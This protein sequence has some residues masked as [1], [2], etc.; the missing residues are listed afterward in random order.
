MY[1]IDKL[2][3]LPCSLTMW[4]K[5][6]FSF[7]VLCFLTECPSVASNGLLGCGGFVKSDIDIN[8]SLVEVSDYEMK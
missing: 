5:Y 3:P 8:F 6:I 1:N 4:T 2:F 7:A